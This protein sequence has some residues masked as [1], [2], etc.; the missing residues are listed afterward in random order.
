MNKIIK[1]KLKTG[2]VILFL[3][4]ILLVSCESK[5]KEELTIAPSHDFE[6]IRNE[7]IRIVKDGKTPSFAVAV[8]QNGKIIWQEV[9]EQ[10][11]DTSTV[12][13][14]ANDQYPIASLTKSMSATVLVKLEEKGKISLNDPIEKYLPNK[15]KY[16][17]RKSSTIKELLNMT[18]GIPHG[19]MYFNTKSP[20]AYITN[21]SLI[22]NYGMAVF[23][24]G[25]YEYSNYAYGIAEA[26]IENVS[27][28]SYAEVLQEELFDPLGMKNSFIT[29]ESINTPENFNSINE[30]GHPSIFR[31]SGG[32]GVYSTLGDLI[33]YARLNLKE[34]DES[35]IS[36]KSL[37]KLH[38]DKIYSS[39]ITSLGWGNITLGDNLT[40]LV[41]NGSFPNSANS[42]LT[43]IPENKI[44]IICLSN[45]DFQSSADIMAIKIADI[46]VPGFANKAFEKM[47]SYESSD[48]KELNMNTNNYKAWHG[49]LE[50]VKTE[51]PIDIIYKNDS[52]YIAFD[53]GEWQ[54]LKYASIDHQS[55][56]RG[57]GL[58]L[59]LKNPITN[60][61][62]ETNGNI[63]LLVTDNKLQ[64][65]LSARFNEEDVFELELPYYI[66]AD[67]I[68]NPD[69]K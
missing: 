49:V 29:S 3:A 21:D 9:F 47:E 17:G 10:N 42:N 6:T 44:A 5:I 18:S 24:E 13:I 56:I 62:V 46:L 36:H 53:K 27:N 15:I 33:L 40:W 8:I 54:S 52:L 61:V 60:Q 67:G 63:N 43:I 58:T 25:I 48:R 2:K 51:L 64:G 65:Y 35:I 26:I 45:R 55:I 12:S 30:L 68:I 1:L 23:P 34:M 69:F 20:F 19:W 41:T 66:V 4:A 28:K 50:N 37:S 59:S 32:A 38:N 7:I 31:P 11:S 14:L 22:S 39:T 16:Y 57:G